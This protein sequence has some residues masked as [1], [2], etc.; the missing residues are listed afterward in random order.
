MFP[1]YQRLH[2]DQLES[3]DVYLRLVIEDKFSAL[4][5]GTQI[6]LE[7]QLP[8]GSCGSSRCIELVIV[9]VL[10]FSTVKGGTRILQKGHSIF[11]VVGKETDSNTSSDKKF[12]VV[13]V[14]CRT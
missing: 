3:L 10:L 9:S 12:L 13:E 11:G 1:T 7:D 5:G 2:T 8:E 6:I 14:E 4:K